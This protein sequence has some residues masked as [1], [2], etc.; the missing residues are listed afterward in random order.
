MG[1][2]STCTIPT[3]IPRRK[4]AVSMQKRL[5]HLESLVKGVMTGEG[6]PSVE[7]RSL[8]VSSVL[9]TSSASQ[10]PDVD[11]SIVETT[12]HGL[13]VPSSLSNLL[14]NDSIHNRSG[15]LLSTSQSTFVGGTHWA[16]IL[17]DIEEVKEYFEEMEEE[18]YEEP[19]SNLV[20]FNSLAFN[21]QHTATKQDLVGA[22]PSKPVVDR[23][24]SRYFNCNSPSVSILHKPKFEKEYQIFWLDPTNAPAS[25]IGLLF[26]IMGIGTFAMLGANEEHPDSRGIPLDM[27]R[28]YRGSC[29]QALIL[30]HYM[31]PGPYTMETFVL[32]AEGEFM[33][34]KGGQFHPYLMIGNMVRLCLHM[35][36]HRDPSKVRSNISPFQAEFRRRLWHHIAQIDMLASFHLGLPGMVEALESDTQYP[37]NLRDEDFNEDSVELPPARPASELTPIS[38]LIYKSVL[39]YE[40]RQVAR[41]TNSLKPYPY[42][43][44]LELDELLHIA[45]DKVPAFYRF[46]P[47]GISILESTNVVIKQFSLFL[48]FHKARCMLHRKYFA[49][50]EYDRR[51]VH[52]RK[53]ALNASMQLLWGQSMTYDAAVLPGGPLAND[54][55]FLSTLATHDF[56]L[57]AMIVFIRIMQI[58]QLGQDQ[59]EVPGMISVLER[60]HLAWSNTNNLS[61]KKATNVSRAMLEKIRAALGSHRSSKDVQSGSNANTEKEISNLSLDGKSKIFF[62]C[63]KWSVGVCPVWRTLSL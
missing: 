9:K 59:S 17:E 29:V 37:R 26:A 3:P 54:K 19:D 53:E 48:V 32:Y 22:L 56:L 4:P 46:G 50:A 43:K 49:L 27:A 2:A 8:E 28:A 18:D 45:F 5:R 51:Y 36:L 35:G 12:G 38:Y 13:N 41:L 62:C 47:S 33:F 39:C 55:W 1:K 6:P 23:L 34:C 25:Y 20:S 21:Y 10:S 42:E 58:I 63:G 57:A 44:V 52:S 7:R 11:T 16:A 60:S 40:C 31:K 15:I 14:A 30:S 61:A 24:I